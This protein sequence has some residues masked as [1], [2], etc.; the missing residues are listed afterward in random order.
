MAPSAEEG[1]TLF[2]RDNIRVAEVEREYPDG[3]VK[4]KAMIA[5]TDVS[6]VV[7]ITNDGKI[8]VERHYRYSADTWT[9]EV[10]AGKVDDGESPDQCAARE[11]EEE[12]GY[13]AR[14]MKRIASFYVMPHR[15]NYK[16]HVYL[17]TGLS[18]TRQRL[19]KDE[20]I[21]VREET[22]DNL[23]LM[24]KNGELVDQKTATA[25]LYYSAFAKGD[26][27]KC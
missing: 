18:K 10:P 19:E 2:D 20:F 21:E 12:T 23:M 26:M 7:P 25:L 22:L 15:S 16:I 24:L 3:S 27:P 5:L 14:E 17:A 13:K 8:L 9:T 6:V 1:K 4:K 11:L